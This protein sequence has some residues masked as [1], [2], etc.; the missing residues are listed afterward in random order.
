MGILTAWLVYCGAISA[1]LLTAA[2]AWE[3]S[4]RWSGR[5]A[6]WGWATALAGSAALPW[7]LR[8]VPE[9]A[10]PEVMPALQVLPAPVLLDPIG[11]ADASAAAAAPVMSAG[12]VGVLLWAALSVLM[13]AW[14]GWAV[15]R[16]GMARR[17]WRAAE[18]EGGRV[19]ISADTG[20]AAL[21]LRQGLVVVP[22]W[23]LELRDDVRSLLL[24]HEREHVRAGDPRLLFFG[25]VCVAAMPWNPLLWVQL[26]RLRNAIELDCDARVLARGVSPRAYGTLLL[27]V[28]RRRGSSPLVMA[29]FAEPRVFLEER[30]RRIAHWPMQRSRSR[31][32]AFAAVAVALFIAAL[33]ARDPLRAGPAAEGVSLLPL[34]GSAEQ[35][36]PVPQDGQGNP[37]FELEPL[38]AEAARASE[39][40]LPPVHLAAVD[41]PPR[42]ERAPVFTPMTQRPQLRN[43]E[44]VQ[45][46]LLG[47][48][49]AA[50]RDAG[51]GGTVVVWF[52]IDDEG[53]VQRTQISRPSGYPALDEAALQVAS[54]MEF[55]PAMNRDQRVAVWVEIPIVFTARGQTPEQTV[56]ITAE[57]AAAAAA[58]AAAAAPRPEGQ[59]PTAL[60]V[61]PELAN[62]AEV[63]RWLVRNFPPMLRDAGISGTPVVWYYVGTDGR[64]L[65]MQLALPSG[66]PA[67]DEVALGAASQMR[68]T[69]GREDGRPAEMW[70]ELPISFQG[71][72]IPVLEQRGPNPAIRLEP[73][74]V[75]GE[76]G[77]VAPGAAAARPPAP[78]PS[79]PQRA[80]SAPAA[81]R[82]IADGPTFTPMTTRPELR[83]TVEVQR[84]L[85][86]NY[87]PVLRDA[88]IGGAPTLWFLIDDEGTVVDTRISRASGY[89]ALDEAAMAVAR[90]MQFSPALNR[91]Q[92]VPVW[93]EIPIVFTAR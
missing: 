92:R 76:R 53:R 41:T 12:E 64:V 31:A 58:Q 87:P 4:A 33:G 37:F 15:V 18:L 51:I 60:R 80:A 2:L 81:L 88:G 34:G 84:A 63:Q 54:A 78:Q 86:R 32:V 22:A 49:P 82:A 1:V 55:A 20:P 71:A 9:R 79:A 73:L 65:R 83:N 67:L 66:H 38:H 17:R 16:I 44:D 90:I 3:Y 21:G 52:F 29:T 42:I 89:P 14:V 91:E 7:L 56:R 72:P 8:L 85:V 35:A 46:I 59:R 57:R 45:R 48:Y 39:P 6:R 24:A 47:A 43:P 93:V 77:D 25:L 74:R 40:E 27:E 70:V 68:F 69:P 61:R 5:S 75:N 26:L 11:M 28:G 23:V 10:W 62:A 50:L 30:I 36:E 13:V 19:F